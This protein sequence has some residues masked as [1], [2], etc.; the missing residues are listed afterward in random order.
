M[1]GQQQVPP[2]HQA[3]LHH[4]ALR[5]VHRLGEDRWKVDVPPIGP[6]LTM[7]QLHFG[8]IAYGVSSFRDLVY[9]LGLRRQEKRP[10][11]LLALLKN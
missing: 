5:E 9:K 4:L 10:Q 1:P 7:N 3:P 6:S 11:N 8:R 2:V